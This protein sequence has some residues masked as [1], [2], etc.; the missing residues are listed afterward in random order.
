MP[1]TGAK[2]NVRYRRTILTIAIAFA[3]STVACSW[4]ERLTDDNRSS[5]VTDVLRELGAKTVGPPEWRVSQRS[6]F[7]AGLEIEESIE[8]HLERQLPFASFRTIQEFESRSVDTS[9]AERMVSGQGSTAGRFQAEL[10]AVL[11]NADATR[12]PEVALGSGTLF[13]AYSEALRM[14]A[15]AAGIDEVWQLLQPSDEDV[16]FVTREQYV[17]AAA[18]LGL[19]RDGLL[20]LR[21]ACSQYAASYPTLEPE[22]RNS[23]LEELEGHYVRAVRDWLQ[24]AE[25]D[26]EFTP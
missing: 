11:L 8:R 6:F 13:E 26:D 19:T 9:Q 5:E 22:I 18:A 14:C 10:N 16:A 20:D 15:S 17:N 21:S 24:Q 25:L 12:A 2:P 7:D 1:I 4:P 3:M 23:L